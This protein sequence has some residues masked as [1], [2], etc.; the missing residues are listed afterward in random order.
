V[1]ALS[2]TLPGHWW[3]TLNGEAVTRKYCSIV[4]D[5]IQWPHSIGSEGK[6]SVSTRW[7]SLRRHWTERPRLRLVITPRSSATM[8]SPLTS[9]AT[10]TKSDCRNESNVEMLATPRLHDTYQNLG[11]T[12][13]VTTCPRIS[14]PT[15]ICQDSGNCRATWADT[16]PE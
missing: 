11:N 15:P 7:T 1:C 4:A 9:L 6:D 16:W 12:D 3:T 13:L 5:Y 2:A 10:I 14:L 8:A